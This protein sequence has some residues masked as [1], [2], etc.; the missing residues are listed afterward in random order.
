MMS[1]MSERSTQRIR[2]GGS[3]EDLCR[4]CKCLRR[5]TV[6]AVAGDRVRV[7]CETCNSQ[8][9]YRGAPT[10]RSTPRRTSGPDTD[11]GATGFPIVSPQ[12]R[13]FPPMSDSGNSSDLELM[14]RRVIREETGLTAVTP[15]PK[16]HGGELVLRPGRADVQEKAWPIETF[17]QKIVMVRN[18]LRTLEQ[19]INAAELPDE[20][21][22]KIQSY[23]TG[24][25]GSLTSFNVL[26]ADDDD[27]FKGSSGK[28]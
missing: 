17:F 9:N 20:T 22:L 3:I 11:H 16:W 4:A 14:L 8:H 1:G 25:Y 18:R 6:T 19:Q 5:H 27:R 15:A 7:I 2:V 13:R 28:T 26:F 12:E 21:K 24:C 10:P 23:I